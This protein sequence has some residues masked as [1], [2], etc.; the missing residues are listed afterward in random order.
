MMAANVRVLGI[1]IANGFSPEARVF[2]ELLACTDP[3]DVEPHLLFQQLPGDTTSAH[4][5]EEATGA[6]V[7]PVDFGWRSVAAGRS[8]RER[9]TG[10]ARFLAAL[11]RALALARRIDPDV[12]YSCQQLWDCQVATYLARRLRKPQVVHLHYTVGPW[13]HRPILSRLRSCDH[14]IAISDF[15]AQ[16]AERFGVPAER[17]TTIRNT[18]TVPAAGAGRDEALRRELGLSRSAPVVGIIARLDPEKG[19]AD[20]LAA[21]ARVLRRYPEARLLVVGDETP[22]H[23]GY[24]AGLRK[25]AAELEIAHAVQFLG[26]R[27]DV[28]RIL[29]ALDVFVH[30]SRREPCGLAVLE[31]SAAA[32]PVV[33]YA[34]G[35][36]R[37]IVEHG[38]TGLLAA[39]GDVAE[40]A[41]Q[42]C[43]LLGNPMR[44]REMGAF[45]RARMRREFRPEEAGQRFAQVLGGFGTRDPDHRLSAISPARHLREQTPGRAED[46]TA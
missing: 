1:Q 43:V 34:E 30:P 40:L 2:A 13:L 38:L 9:L 16:E 31:A 8:L 20:T 39:P 46:A 7:L 5:F 26:R 32:L 18:I 19:Q 33:A 35:G 41:E 37:E 6:H 15:I 42:L 14:V 12:I 29:S 36:P 4:R 10:R 24:G 22:W 17:L 11:P 21:F 27:D 25:L 3:R 45:G 23:P 44:A 28:P